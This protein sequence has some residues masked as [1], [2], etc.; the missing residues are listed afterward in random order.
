MQQ[1]F[2]LLFFGSLAASRFFY[3]LK[4][5]IQVVFVSCPEGSNLAKN[6]QTDS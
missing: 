3:L 1:D 5:F 2:W 4:Q 6:C